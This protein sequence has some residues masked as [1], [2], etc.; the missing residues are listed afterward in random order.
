M[1]E[2]YRYTT[3]TP[4]ADH[5]IGLSYLVLSG[6]V[7]A[8]TLDDGSEGYSVHRLES[9]SDL[10]G[11]CIIKGWTPLT[12]EDVRFLRTH[13]GLYQEDLAGLLG[14]KRITVTRMEK[15]IDDA[16][17]RKVPRSRPLRND[18]DRH[19]RLLFA[20]MMGIVG[21]ADLMRS[22]GFGVLNGSNRRLHLHMSDEGRWTVFDTN[23]GNGEGGQFG[24]D[25]RQ[26]R[27]WPCRIIK[28]EHPQDLPVAEI[29]LGRCTVVNASDLQEKATRIASAKG[30]ENWLAVDHRGCQITNSSGP[31]KSLW[32]LE[33]V[34]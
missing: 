12:G 27:V 22:P 13:L 30:E 20:S 6:G 7:S 2:K 29:E 25:P 24:A 21:V 8:W 33:T 23:F 15:E 32:E 5:C 4:F 14:V 26:H 28:G 18:M 31:T 9:L 34:P 17:G 11:A 19:V 16:N 10:A 1:F 3:D